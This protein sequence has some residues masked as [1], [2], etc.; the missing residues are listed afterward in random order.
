LES[1]QLLPID[2]TLFDSGKI[3]NYIFDH[4]L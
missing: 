3:N 4:A 1:V 2:L